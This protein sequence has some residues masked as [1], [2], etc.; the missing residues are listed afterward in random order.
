M[1]T[2]RNGT[3]CLWK[4]PW[5]SEWNHGVGV[6][7]GRCNSMCKSSPASGNRS[8]SGTKRPLWL[9]LRVRG[10]GVLCYTN[11]DD[12]LHLWKH[13]A[14]SDKLANYIYTKI[15][16]MKHLKTKQPFKPT[17]LWALS[18]VHLLH[19]DSIRSMLSHL[20]QNEAQCS[21]LFLLQHWFSSVFMFFPLQTCILFTIWKIHSLI[22]TL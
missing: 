5:R 11:K 9:A 14:I 7:G 2:W 18:K 20:V 13:M 17:T 10:W 19:L 3:L 16:P 22:P 12:A 1:S 6:F 4:V 21:P 8:L 15:P